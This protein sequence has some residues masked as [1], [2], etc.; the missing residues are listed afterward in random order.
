MAARLPHRE[1]PIIFVERREGES[2]LSR[3]V[4]VESLI[5]PWRLLRA[6]PGKSA[7]C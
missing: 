4:L 1:V 5:A 7:A 3:G 6:L 2:K